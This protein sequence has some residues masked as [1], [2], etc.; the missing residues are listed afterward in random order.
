MNRKALVFCVH[1][2]LNNYDCKIHFTVMS[3]KRKLHAFYEV[4]IAHGLELASELL[5]QYRQLTAV[6]AAAIKTHAARSA[7]QNGKLAK[8]L[9]RSAARAPTHYLGL[10][11][12]IENALDNSNEPY[13]LSPAVSSFSKFFIDGV[14]EFITF[15][16]LYNL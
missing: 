10:V 1:L 14:V 12:T 15:A 16:N 3:C 4:K 11:T 9:S 2:H 7:A 5:M 8:H 13:L 6:E